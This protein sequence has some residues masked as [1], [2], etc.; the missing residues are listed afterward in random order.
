MI[1][2]DIYGKEGTHAHC[3]S[4]EIPLLDTDNMTLNYTSH[5]G[6]PAAAIVPFSSRCCATPNSGTDPAPRCCTHCR[7]H[8]QTTSGP[9][10][11]SSVTPSGDYRCTTVADVTHRFCMHIHSSCMGIEA[12]APPEAPL[13]LIAS[14]VVIMPGFE[15]IRG[16]LFWSDRKI[17]LGQW[18]G[19]TDW[20]WCGEP[21]M[22]RNDLH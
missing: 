15:P 22:M 18:S 9:S 2:E 6:R 4:N 5:P 7:V 8:D 1:G 14:R 13:I 12:Q 20:I 3:A 11:P 19:A 16:V 17:N 10:C 21:S